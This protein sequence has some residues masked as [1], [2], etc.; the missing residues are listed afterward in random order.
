MEMKGKCKGMEMEMKGKC[1][2]SCMQDADVKVVDT[3]DGVIITITAKKGGADI[4]TI[5]ERAKMCMAKQTEELTGDDV[6]T[7]PVMGTRIKKD[8]AFAKAEYKGKTYY[9]CCLECKDAFVKNPE[10]YAVK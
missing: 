10:K 6:V 2:M 5:Q 9:F 4:K 8:R 1:Q 7:C 3:K